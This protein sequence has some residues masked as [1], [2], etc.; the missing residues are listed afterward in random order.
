[1]IEVKKC[2][3]STWHELPR[4]TEFSFRRELHKREITWSEDLNYQRDKTTLFHLRMDGDYAYA[5]QSADGKY[6]CLLYPD[7]VLIR[8][9][10]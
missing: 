1:M 8:A 9:H 2:S 5:T 4:D 7:G 3:L 10:I 6:L